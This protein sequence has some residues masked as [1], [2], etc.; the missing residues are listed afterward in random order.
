MNKGN[1]IKANLG[2]PSI[3][4]II[5]VLALSIFALLALRSSEGEKKLARKTADSVTEYYKMNG[6][7]EEILA[8]AEEIIAIND[9]NAAKEQL[10]S[11]PEVKDVTTDDVSGNISAIEF[12]V[13]AENNDRTGL[14]V[15]LT[16]NGTG[17]TPERW[18]VV[19]SEPE[20]GYNTM[21]L[22]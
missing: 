16:F 5:L 12:Y 1:S 22:D 14:D 8:Q 15:C 18:K 19:V 6:R 21:L 7:A 13:A 10:L 9:A 2:G 17:L 3:I 20:E 4:L 11:I